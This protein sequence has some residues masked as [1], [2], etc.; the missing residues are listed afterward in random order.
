MIATAEDFVLFARDQIGKPYI[1]GAEVSLAD[2]DPPAFDCSEL[3]EWALAACDIEIPDGSMRQLEHC[4]EYSCEITIEQAIATRGA[5]LFR[6]PTA[7]LGAHVAISLGNGSTIEARGKVYGV[8]EA[9]TEGRTWTAAAL[10]PGLCYPATPPETD[11]GSS[12]RA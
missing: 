8:V 11:S 5:L 9:P 2:P 4:R 3:V 7:T 6:E 12:I 1:F 10:V